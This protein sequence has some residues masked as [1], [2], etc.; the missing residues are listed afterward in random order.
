LSLFGLIALPVAVGGV[1]DEVDEEDDVRE[2]DDDVEK[3]A[4]AEEEGGFPELSCL[5][6]SA[7]RSAYL[8][9]YSKHDIQQRRQLTKP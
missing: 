1:L 6:K 5:I 3:E 9:S 8:V 7:A 4:E 2:A